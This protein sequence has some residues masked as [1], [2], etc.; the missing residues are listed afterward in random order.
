MQNNLHRI[1]DKCQISAPP[2]IHELHRVKVQGLELLNRIEQ[3]NRKKPID[4]NER[5]AK[6][7]GKQAVCGKEKKKNEIKYH[8][9]FTGTMVGKLVILASIPPAYALAAG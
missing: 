6:R 2:N 9:L 5:K 1:E 8:G 4:E 7:L 3:E